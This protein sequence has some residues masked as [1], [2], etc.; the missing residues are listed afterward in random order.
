MPAD[1]QFAAQ[2]KLTKEELDNAQLQEAKA[3][4]EHPMRN[5]ESDDLDTKFGP[6]MR[7]QRRAI[8]NIESRLLGM[9]IGFKVD[10][11]EVIIEAPLDKDKSFMTLNNLMLLADG[12]LTYTRRMFETISGKKL[13]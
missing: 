9:T 12:T 6:G 4:A 7:I 10:T 5:K 11:R 13:R 2:I 1:L 3:D 8:K